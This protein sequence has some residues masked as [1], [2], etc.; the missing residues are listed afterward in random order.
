PFRRRIPRVNRTVSGRSTRSCRKA[1]RP[2]SMA[3]ASHSVG[4]LALAV[5]LLTSP[6]LAQFDRIFQDEPPR[7]PANV[8]SAPPEDG[9]QPGYYPSQQYPRPQSP[10]QQDPN[11]EY[12]SRQY[13]QQQYP[14]QQYPQQQYP[15]QQQY[16]SR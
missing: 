1:K 15:Q 11:R 3:R 9:Q 12:G 7:P 6:A 8:P 4:L 5:L 10:S 2:A 16:P 13:P 14:Q